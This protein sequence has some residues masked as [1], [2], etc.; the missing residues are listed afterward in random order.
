M[1]TLLAMIV[2][3]LTV[4]R[5]T[6]FAPF[7]TDVLVDAFVTVTFCPVG[8]VRVKLDSDALSTVPV[9]PPAAGPE[10]AL[11]PPPWKAG[12]NEVGAVAAVAEGE[13]LL[14]HYRQTRQESP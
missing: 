8:V 6:T 3:P 7:L 13:P 12:L 2:V 14:L 9:V 10:R 4:P 1:S 11:D 5:T